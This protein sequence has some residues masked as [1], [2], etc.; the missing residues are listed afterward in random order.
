MSVFSYFIIRYGSFYISVM[1]NISKILWPKFFTHY[2][3]YTLTYVNLLIIFLLTHMFL[4]FLDKVIWSPTSLKLITLH[5]TLYECGLLCSISK[6]GPFAHP[7]KLKIFW[8]NLTISFNIIS[9]F[10]PSPV[11]S[12]TEISHKYDFNS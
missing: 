7:H 5:W 3:R 10:L 6:W 2:F 8:I 1:K 9:I 11:N 4:F 12:A